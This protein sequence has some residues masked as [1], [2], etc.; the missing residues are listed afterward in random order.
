[1]EA[2]IQ[3]A[4]G[5]GNKIWLLGWYQDKNNTMELLIKEE[6]DK[7]ILRQRAGGRIVKKQAAT[8]ITIAPNISYKFKIAFDG[9]Q[10]VVSVDSVNAITFAPAV[11]VPTGTVGFQV[12][13]TIGRFG[14]INVQ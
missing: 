6:N 1:M 5:V 13:N 2:E 14:S 9:A 12:K 4:G 10:F 7:I 3:T 8:H 11:T